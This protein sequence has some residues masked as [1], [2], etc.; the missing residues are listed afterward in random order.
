[1]SSAFFSLLTTF[2][3]AFIVVYLLTLFSLLFVPALLFRDIVSEVAVSAWRCCWWSIVININDENNES[4][5]D[6]DTE[7][8]GKEAFKRNL[9]IRVNGS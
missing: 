9:Q 2:C 8:D 6:E 5:D 4:K 7:E 1:M 3:H